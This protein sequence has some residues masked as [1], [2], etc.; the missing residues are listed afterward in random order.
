MLLLRI[1]SPMHLESAIC[2]EVAL[3]LRTI[4]CCGYGCAANKTLT[5]VSLQNLFNIDLRPS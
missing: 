5:K 1:G 3:L 2:L 4:D